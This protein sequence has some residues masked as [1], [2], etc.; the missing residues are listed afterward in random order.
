MKAG[1]GTDRY[2]VMAVVE[3]KKTSSLLLCLNP[4]YAVWKVPILEAVSEDTVQK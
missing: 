4:T 1:R 3:E 2:K